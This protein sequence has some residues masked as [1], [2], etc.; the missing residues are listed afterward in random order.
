MYYEIAA[1]ATSE[2]S[3]SKSFHVFD[4][5]GIRFTFEAF[6][7]EVRDDFLSIYPGGAENRTLEIVAVR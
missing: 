7:T 5:L 2:L 3:S 4:I 6:N 1:F